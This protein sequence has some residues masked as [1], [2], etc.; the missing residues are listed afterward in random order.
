MVPLMDE[1]DNR[2]WG[3]RE[4][5]QSPE[6]PAF[7]WQTSYIFIPSHAF[8]GQGIQPNCSNYMAKAVFRE[9]RGVGTRRKAVCG[10]G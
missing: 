1:E 3:D 4:G 5:P 7:K 8:Q 2:E 10:T 6:L 9:M